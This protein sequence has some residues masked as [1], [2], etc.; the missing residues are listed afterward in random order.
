M[1]EVLGRAPA[2]G[3]TTVDVQ[4]A[5]LLCEQTR[6]LAA[7]IRLLRQALRTRFASRLSGGQQAS[8]DTVAD[9]TPAADSGPAPG[10]A[11]ELEAPAVQVASTA[12]RSFSATLEERKSGQGSHRD[13]DV[14]DLMEQ[15]TGRVRDHGRQARSQSVEARCQLRA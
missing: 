14:L 13:L 8:E 7:E 11:G 4:D 12:F 2:A 9:A 5:R 1:D 10:Q 3:V 6:D 15:V